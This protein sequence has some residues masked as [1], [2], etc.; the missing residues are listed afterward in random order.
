M[1]PLFPAGKAA[2]AV[3][4]M[5]SQPNRTGKQLEQSS[6]EVAGAAGQRGR[7]V[8]AGETAGAGL[9]QHRRVDAKESSRKMCGTEQGQ[10]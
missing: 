4:G 8:G 5:W 7:V 1:W 2:R 9:G 6:C 10:I 3:Q